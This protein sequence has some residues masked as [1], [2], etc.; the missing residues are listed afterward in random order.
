MFKDLRTYSRHTVSLDNVSSE[1]ILSAQWEVNRKSMRA[2]H[3]L[4][5]N[6]VHTV[7]VNVFTGHITASSIELFY[8]FLN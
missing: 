4:Y 3:M 2:K 8:V 1:L 7:Y 6:Y 5:T